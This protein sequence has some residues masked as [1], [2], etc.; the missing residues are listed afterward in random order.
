MADF[1]KFLTSKKTFSVF[2]EVK[3]F[4]KADDVQFINLK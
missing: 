4:F 1:S 2:M 3:D